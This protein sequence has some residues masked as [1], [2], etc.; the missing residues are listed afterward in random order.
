MMMY[1]VYLGS[2]REARHRGIL[3][4]NSAVKGKKENSSFGVNNVPLINQV[5]CSMFEEHKYFSDSPN[6]M[7]Q[8]VNLEV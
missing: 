3:C 1:T 5:P 2:Q 6:A 8:M 4:K 7:W